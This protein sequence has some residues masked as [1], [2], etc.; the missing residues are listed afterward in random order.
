MKIVFSEHAL[1]RIRERKIS[2]LEVYAT[3][4]N[5]QGKD[6]TYKERILLRRNFGSKIL[7]TAVRIEE[8]CIIVISAYY[9]DRKVYESKI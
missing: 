1:I 3:I 9:L 5:P 2:K 4:Q 7:E 8:K 6:D